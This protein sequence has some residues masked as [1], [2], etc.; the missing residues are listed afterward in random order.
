[1]TVPVRW[2]VEVLAAIVRLTVPFP[3]PLA[4]PLIVIQPTSLVAV[5]AQL[6]DVDTE[7]DPLPPAAPIDMD[8]GDSE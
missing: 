5:H 1:M 2:L 3:V 4:L 8:A 7:N 6:N